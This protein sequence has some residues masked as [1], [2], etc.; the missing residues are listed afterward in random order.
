MQSYDVCEAADR[1]SFV[2]PGGRGHAWYAVT[3]GDKIFIEPLHGQ[4]AWPL[5]MLD[6][7]RVHRRQ[8]DFAAEVSRQVAYRTGASADRSLLAIQLT[9]MRGLFHDGLMSGNPDVS[10]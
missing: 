7:M 3:G 10:C 2:L 4:L 8:D 5:V 6:C 9:E 1:A